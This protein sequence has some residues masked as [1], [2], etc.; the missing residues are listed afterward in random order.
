MCGRRE[1]QVDGFT[2]NKFRRDFQCRVTFR[3]MPRKRIKKTSRGEGDI[4]LY[5]NAC[6]EV[7]LR[8]SLRH[9]A[10]NKA[11]VQ[12]ETLGETFQVKRGVRQGDPMSPK[13][14]SAV[15]QNTFR[16]LIWD[17]HGLNI[18]GQKLNHL[19]FA[20]DIVLFEEETGTLEKMIQDLNKEEES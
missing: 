14:F 2:G 1:L 6:D 4:S 5:K 16:K 17:Q 18:D 19:R 8:A 11:R 7:K 15:L 9:A 20:D 13:L 12:L 10:E 3:A